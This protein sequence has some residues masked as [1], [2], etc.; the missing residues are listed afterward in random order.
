MGS[1]SLL[2]SR[3]DNHAVHSSAHVGSISV[4]DYFFILLEYQMEIFEKVS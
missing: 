1:H 3:C 4:K 2:I